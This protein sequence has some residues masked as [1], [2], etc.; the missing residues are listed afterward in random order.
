M[1]TQSDNTKNLRP[2]AKGAAT[3]LLNG[4]VLWR[5]W[6]RLG[7][8]EIRRR[9]RR[10]VIVPFWSAISLG[11]FVI[12]LGSL[13]TGLW[14]RSAAEY[15]PFLAAGFVVWVM[16]AAILTESCSIFRGDAGKFGQAQLEYSLLVYALLWRNLI[17][18]SHN[19]SLYVVVC[20]IFAPQFLSPFL[21]LALPGLLLV[22]ING[23]W[24]ALLLGMFALR[25]RDIAQFIQ[26]I[27]NV[28][29]FIT[30]IFWLPDA[31]SGFKKILFVNLNPLYHLIDVVRG[32]M[33]GRFPEPQSYIAVSVL[34]I[35]GWLLAYLVFSKFSKRIA[36]WS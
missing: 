29:M 2:L 28:V 22:V 17:A 21:L 36:Y 23:A 5:I 31:L 18:F 25:F 32:P 15:V 20:L 7:W 11:M 12:A 9:Y 14:N 6:G 27:V 30:P 19:L 1:T 13:G 16:V 24:I 8:L 3:D 26:G 10:T 34:A 4:L 35:F 33:L